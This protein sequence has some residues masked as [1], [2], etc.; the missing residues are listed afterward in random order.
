MP[1]EDSENVI[2]TC[3]KL[4]EEGFNAIPHLPARTIKDYSELEKYI[5]SLSEK[6]GCKKIFVYQ[7]T[8]R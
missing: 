5:G 2:K 6:A 1:D 4:T 3:K 7:Q 8:H